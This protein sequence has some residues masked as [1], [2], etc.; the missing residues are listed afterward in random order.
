MEDENS[1]EK[2]LQDTMKNGPES[3][4]VLMLT[5]HDLFKMPASVSLQ[6]LFELAVCRNNL[7]IIKQ[8]LE[9]QPALMFV[10]L[11]T[12][13]FNILQIALRRGDER[14]FELLLKL[15]PELMSSSE[16]HGD[17]YAGFGDYE[18][19]R[20]VVDE[21]H[22]KVLELIVQANPLIGESRDCVGSNLFHHACSSSKSI[23][24]MLNCGNVLHYRSGYSGETPFEIAVGAG[25]TDIVAYMLSIDPSVVDCQG[26]YDDDDHYEQTENRILNVAVLGGNIS[27][28]QT[29]LDLRPDLLKLLKL[30]VS[31]YSEAIQKGDA[32]VCEF[33]LR[34][35]PGLLDAVDHHGQ[36]VLVIAALHG[37]EAI[38]AMLLSAKP[39]L[40]EEL[41]SGRRTVLHAASM[42]KLTSTML[43][44]FLKAKPN[45][46]QAV[47]C[48]GQTVMHCANEYAVPILFHAE[49]NLMN[50]KDSKGSTPVQCAL[51]SYAAERILAFIKISPELIGE[52]GTAIMPVAVCQKNASLVKYLLEQDP[53]LVYMQNE[54]FSVL[55]QVVS[56]ASIDLVELFQCKLCLEDTLLVYT[57]Y[58][59]REARDLLKVRDEKVEV[60]FQELVARYLR[61]LAQYVYVDVVKIVYHYVEIGTTLDITAILS[62]LCVRRTKRKPVSH[63]TKFSE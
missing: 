58:K 1:R 6:N 12:Q 40:V 8:F 38:I 13:R 60:R 20:C 63:D 47:D 45:L 3:E 35:S 33:M 42:G 25:N 19:L 39:A 34:T 28:I 31:H 43:Q 61:M 36:N 11:G 21:G 37:H 10:S 50:I 48:E 9:M 32:R 29:I 4:V 18:S 26:G 27:I 30:D 51:Q 15:N 53:E 16:W 17:D 23:V 14:L 52:H 2:Q 56:D 22:E 5:D 7:A 44:L 57:K 54:G 41:Y 59:M 46:M 55:E 24:E 62:D 49:P